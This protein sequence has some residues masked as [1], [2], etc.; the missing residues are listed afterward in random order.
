MPGRYN[1]TEQDPRRYQINDISDPFPFIYDLTYKAAGRSGLTIPAS[2]GSDVTITTPVYTPGSLSRPLTGDKTETLERMFDGDSYTIYM[3]VKQID[4]ISAMGFIFNLGHPGSAY[5][6]G[7]AMFS[8][9]SNWYFAA[10]DGDSHKSETVILTDPNTNFKS[11]DWVEILCQVN[12]TTKRL[13]V[14]MRKQSDQ[15]TVGTDQDYDIS[16]WTFTAADNDRNYLFNNNKFAYCDFKKFNGVKTL[17]QCQDAT[18]VT[19]VELYYPTMVDGTDVS[20]NDHHLLMNGDRPNETDTYYYTDISSYLLDYG[21]SLYRSPYAGHYFDQAADNRYYDIY[22]PHAPDGSPVPRTLTDPNLATYVLIGTFAGSAT[23]HNMA[24]CKLDIPASEWDRDDTD[25]YED[26]VRSAYYYA[27]GNSDEWHI[28]E[29]DYLLF[30]QRCKTGY[31]GINFFK[32]SDDSFVNREVLDMIFSYVSNKSGSD[33]QKV[34]EYTGDKV[35][36]AAALNFYCDASDDPYIPILFKGIADEDSIQIYWGDGDKW[37]SILMD[38]SDQ[39]FS[40]TYSGSETYDVYIFNPQNLLKYSDHGL[41]TFAPVDN[42]IGEFAKCTNLTYLNWWNKSVWLVG[43]ITNLPLSLET[44]I[45]H[46]ETVTGD[47]TPFENL[48]YAYAYWSVSGDMSNML[49]IEHISF[50]WYGLSSVTIDVTLLTKLISCHIQDTPYARLTGDFTNHTAFKELCYGSDGAYHKLEGDIS[51]LV[52]LEYWD[53]AHGETNMYGSI[54]GLTNLYLFQNNNTL[55]VLTGNLD[56]LVNLERFVIVSALC[57][58]TK[59][60]TL[61]HI[62]P[63]CHFSASDWVYTEAEVNQYLAD[64]WANRD[65]ARPNLSNRAIYLWQ[66]GSASPTGQGITDKAALQAY[67]SP[68]DDPAFDLWTIETL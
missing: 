14:Q 28:S 61:A 63:L 24:N 46:G 59:P 8:D 42:D 22:V 68:N 15:T 52:N 53:L 5:L 25:I 37:E 6:R 4:D 43:V 44:I 36:L 33:L 50:T 49:N 55:M 60:A 57:S 48:V 35:A 31:K 10:A 66:S 62:T 65:V 13:V 40:K 7:M 32:I 29:L 26:V 16:A 17:A 9:A 47:I 3:K 2:T 11:K 58:I 64:L 20:G 1:I 21:Y 41:N 54:S 12:F 30:S 23:E 38:E 34:L 19:D 51:T 56:A 39:S 67:R 18:Y 27:A 45:I